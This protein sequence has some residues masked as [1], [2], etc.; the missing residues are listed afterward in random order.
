MPG[1]VRAHGYASTGQFVG[2]DM[3][4]KT[5]TFGAAITQDNLDDLVAA[6]QQTSTIEVIG[7]VVVGTDTAVNMIISGANTDDTADA[8]VT[9]CTGSDVSGFEQGR[10]L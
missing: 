2:R 1:V 7:E 4:Y 5:Y 8:L 3:W 9:G 6:I 10:E